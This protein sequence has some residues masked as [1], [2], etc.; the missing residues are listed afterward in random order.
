MRSLTALP[1]LC[2]WTRRRSIT[3]TPRPRLP[4]PSR[5][6]VANVW[7]SSHS[8]RACN[9]SSTRSPCPSGHETPGWTSWLAN[10][11]GHALYAPLLEDPASHGNTARFTFF[12]PAARVFFSEW[13]QNAS[14][15]VATLR[16]Y[17]GQNPRDKRPR[18]DDPQ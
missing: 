7:W 4:V 14:D 1:E 10:A 5:S 3:C 6:A 18:A 12:S 16:S 13:E 2:A 9:G 17:A 15:I 11:Q 8:F